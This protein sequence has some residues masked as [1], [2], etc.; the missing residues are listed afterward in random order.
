MIKVKDGYAKL[1]GTTYTGSTDRVLLSNGGDFGL[2]TGRNNEANKIVRTDASGY[3][4]AGWINTTSGDMGTSA[5]NRIYCSNDGYIRY[6]T[7]ANFFST[8]ANDSNQLSITVGSQNRKL[9]VAY[10]TNS[11]TVDGLHASDFQRTW[12]GYAGKTYIG[13]I[14]IIEWTLTR[15]DHFSPYSF[16][17]QVYRNYNSPSS[18]S[19]TLAFNFGWDSANIVQLN[20]N[21]GSRIIESFRV[22]KT[23]DGLKYFVEMYVNTSYTT[24]QNT[25]YFAIGNYRFFN[26][27]LVCAIQSETVTELCKITT[28]P[29]NIVAPGYVKQGSSDSYVLLGGGGHKTIDSF[30]TTY[31][32]RYVKKAG[33]TMTGILTMNTGTGIQMKYTINGDDPWIYPNGYINYGIRYFK[34]NPD[35]MTL[36]ASGNNNSISGADLCINGNGD[37]TVT[38]RGKNIL[39]EATAPY[40][41]KLYSRNDYEHYVV[42]LCKYGIN[43]TYTYHRA[44]GKIYSQYQGGGR[45]VAADIDV[46]VSDWSSGMNSKLRFDTYGIQEMDLVTCTYSGIKYLAIR[47]RGVQ[48][49]TVYFEG[50]SANILFTPIYY[51]NEKTGSVIN[52]EVN[53]SITTITVGQPYSNGIKYALVNDSITG[54]AASA[55]KVIV[56][57]HTSN[58]I[59]YPLIWSNQNNTN[60]V[61]ENQLFKSYSHLTYNPSIHRISTG[62]YIANNSA[63][64]H[65]TA[66]STIGNWAYLRLHNGSTYWDIATKSDFGSGGL[67]LARLSGANNGIFVSANSTPKVGINTSS[68][69][70]TLHVTGDSYTTG[71]SRASSG[72]Q[73]EGKG[74]H[75][76]SNNAS[77]LGQIYL[78]SN[79]FNWSA[80][81][82]TLHFNYRASANGTTVTSYIWNA[83]SSTTYANHTTGK[84]DAK[85]HILTTN[86]FGINSTSGGGRGISLYGGSD[87]V[88]T[89]G[90]AFN[91]TS[92]WGTHG[93]VTSDWATYFTMNNQ[94][95]R[96]WI[97]RRNGSGNAFSIDTSGQVYANGSVNGNYFT[98]RVAT[99][100]SPLSVSSRT[101]CNNLNA[102][103][104]D[105]YHADDI[106][107]YGLENLC[108]GAVASGANTTLNSDGSITT[109]GI[110]SDTYF[111][112][113][114]T[115]DLIAG[116]IY[117]VGFYVTGVPSGN[118]A[119]WSW[120]FASQSNN[121]L[122][123]NIRNN[124]WC[125]GTGTIPNDIAAGKNIIF[126]DAGR[127][128]CSSINISKFVIVK[129][130]QKAYYTPPISK[131]S[132]NHAST[133]TVN[134]SDAN[135]AYRMVW[136]S[137]NTLYS[138]AGIYCNPSTDQIYSAGFRHVSY[139]SSTYLLRSDGG[140]ATF[141]WSGQSG[142]PTWLWGGNSQHTY[143][144]YNPS[145][146]NVNSA[147]KLRVVSCYNGT[148][149]NDLW[150]TI[151]SSNSSYLGTATIYEVY[152]DGGPTTYGHV[153][154][155][156][157]VHS[158]HW[159]PQ[160]W[161][162]SGKGGRLRYRNKD[163]NNNSWGDW[164]TV[165]WI[166]DNVASASKWAT[167]RTL[168]L[169]GSVTGSV[170]FDGS[171]DITL[172]TT[173]NHSHSEYLPLAGGTMTGILNTNGQA[174]SW[175]S[176]MTSAAIQY[177]SLKAIDSNSFWKFYNMKSAGGHVVC[178]GGLGN[179]IGFYGYYAGRTANNYDWNFVVNTSNGN[180]I[181]TNSIYAAHFYENSDFQLKTNIQEILNSDKMPIIKEFDWKES[182]KHSYGLI[183][184]ELEEQGYSELVETKEDGYK[185]VNYSAALSLIIG[186]L[187]VKIREL[188][189]EI[190]NL[191]N[192]N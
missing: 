87:Y 190:E 186:K 161:F 180:W 133:V 143:Y 106:L 130:R 68:P 113:R 114:C 79:E 29:N 167:A 38:I 31:D 118:T 110:N 158:N 80:S 159:Q 124:G 17:L 50:T 69:S 30:Q 18:E 52:S 129:G 37:G 123:I 90:I 104:I 57:Q 138:T 126:D 7:P 144:V 185:S 53:G 40:V 127:G 160:L 125:W 140:V 73:V 85:N 166:T 175:V 184:Q 187:Q 141:N 8:L 147:A 84:I 62:Q 58:N 189:K 3:I 115:E 32:D 97:F 82:T 46:F 47:I 16:I 61:T 12:D 42:L 165:A 188:E 99:G 81:T 151:K 67:W 162:D 72:F 77:G 78:T 98:S 48:A 34:G 10:A 91:Q 119:T 112:V 60:T 131:M 164:R 63:G 28:S 173:T 83:G 139:N 13:W 20:S 134:N 15:A 66:N 89:Y 182:G 43:L 86:N 109:S 88:D 1:I 153:L 19:Y 36:S 39:T 75:Y 96:G 102:D 76:M 122:V 6:K 24:Y 132:V 103:M 136:H 163:Y 9:T 26:G 11:D 149:N 35:K 23:A 148:T 92:N 108:V 176:G 142:Q 155:I 49:K 172:A 21:R 59:E 120:P 27:S 55:T 171:G 179:N 93:Y 137:G 121:N 22:T 145:N 174:G 45:Y 192:Q 156:V 54:N 74:V 4:Q 51:Y 135:S 152:N 100:T 41:R 44:S 56:N 64:P 183:A 181:A 170:S 146:F 107:P 5:I 150:S 71:W 191:K 128:F 101:L 2:H 177:N 94:N 65:F 33:D 157:T 178:Y 14:K 111:Q 116:Q 169:T 70:Y 105:G 25:C 168:S 117:T 154:D 95:N